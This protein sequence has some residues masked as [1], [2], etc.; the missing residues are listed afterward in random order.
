LTQRRT[1]SFCT[2]AC[3]KRLSRTCPTKPLPAHFDAFRAGI[4]NMIDMP[5]RTLNNLF[6]FLRQNQGSL[7]TRARENEFAQL[8]PEEVE[9]IEQLYR[10]S[11]PK[12]ELRGQILNEPAKI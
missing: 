7:S 10:D 5:E 1:Q 9:Q 2:N 6:G 12:A 3:A 4:E 11:F 8:T